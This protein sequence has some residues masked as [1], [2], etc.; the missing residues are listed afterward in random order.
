VQ[1]FQ[2]LTIFFIADSKTWQ[3]FE[4]FSISLAQLVEEQAMDLQ[5]HV[6][7]ACFRP[8]PY[9]LQRF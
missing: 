8:K 2:G 6:Q 5:R 3:V 9:Q 7:T 1:H 4:G